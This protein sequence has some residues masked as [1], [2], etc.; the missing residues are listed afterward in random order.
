MRGR[1]SPSQAAEELTVP[2]RRRSLQSCHNLLLRLF[3]EEMRSRGTCA[4]E[5]AKSM[6]FHSSR[7]VRS[8]L[9]TPAPRVKL[10][11]ASRCA[12]P[13]H[14]SLAGSPDRSGSAVSRRERLSDLLNYYGLAS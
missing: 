14:M 6:I 13:P 4:S 5:R 1:K 10:S 7:R 9:S 11:R 8:A 2:E 3:R 12:R